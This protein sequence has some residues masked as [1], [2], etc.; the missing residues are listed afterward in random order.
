M[1]YSVL[2]NSA[3]QNIRKIVAAVDQQQGIPLDCQMT[4]EELN[5]RD[6]QRSDNS[7]PLAF[8]SRGPSLAGFMQWEIYPAPTSSRQIAFLC[9][10]QWPKM[11]DDE[12]IPP[13]FIEPTIF[14][15]KAISIALATRLSKDDA[16]FD[17]KLA[18]YYKNL[19]E[20][21][22]KEAMASDEQLCIQDYTSQL[23]NLMGPGMNSTFWMKHAGWSQIDWN[24]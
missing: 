6:P 16:F 9:S 14:S 10:L 3:N 18:V 12:S 19:A 21:A 11:I 1:Y 7:D 23:S 22:L 4:Q 8:V 15:D 24:F 5:V 20:E 17:P 13:Y 2:A